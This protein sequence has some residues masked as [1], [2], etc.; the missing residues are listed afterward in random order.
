MVIDDVGVVCVAKASQGGKHLLARVQRMRR[1]CPAAPEH[2]GHHPMSV[3]LT[4]GTL[5]LSTRESGTH[6]I[7]GIGTGVRAALPQTRA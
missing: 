4:L 5:T 2:V 3:K 7:H 6:G 1:V